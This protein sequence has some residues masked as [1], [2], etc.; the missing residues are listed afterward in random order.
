MEAVQ[1]QKVTTAMKAGSATGVKT[2]SE[3]DEFGLELDHL[4]A[5]R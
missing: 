2:L 5:D 1:V 3:L 4:L